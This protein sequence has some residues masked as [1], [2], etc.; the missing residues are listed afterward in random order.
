M[1]SH[2]DRQADKTKQLG[3]I[4]CILTCK[5]SINLRDNQLYRQKYNLL[6]DKY[7]VRQTDKTHLLQKRQ[8]NW[9][10]LFAF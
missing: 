4:L 10:A 7:T 1:N 5:P 3:N 8:K 6:T 9:R 2:K